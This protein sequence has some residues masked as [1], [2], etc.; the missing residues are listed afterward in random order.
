MG[1]VVY[2]VL[3]MN[4][5]LSNKI[6]KLE[7]AF[8]RIERDRPSLKSG[9]NAFKE[10]MISRIILKARLSP[11]RP[12][13]HMPQPDYSRF[14]EGHPWLT[15]ETI[16]SLMD[17][18]GEAVESTIL[19]LIKAFPKIAAEAVRLREAFETGDIDLKYCIGALV[20]GRE[21]G[22]IEV[23]S[24]LGFQPTVL[25]FILGQMLK[26]FVEKRTESL[27]PLIENLPWHQGY[28]PICDAFPEISFLRDEESQRW[29]KCSLCGYDWRFD[30]M[31]CPCCG[32]INKGKEFIRVDGFEHEWVELCPDCHRY[33]VGIDLR[34]QKEVT[35]D[36]AA[37]A[38]VHLD[39]IA[40]CRGFL[41]TAESAWK[42][43]ASD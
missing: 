33:I 5:V 28:C 10:I 17:P 21:D 2:E 7:K 3:L 20:E 16:T 31:A 11:D 35:A 32:K 38:M 27:H 37:I 13:I 36:V 22:M 1:N 23:A 29:L 8:D 30:R 41:S 24:H 14:A 6:S 4:E 34:K 25:K 40:Q 43:S 19:S 12:D 9:A 42:Y 18:W 15:G 39:I 26:P